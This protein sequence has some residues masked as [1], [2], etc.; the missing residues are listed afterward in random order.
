MNPW[1]ILG[2]GA[3]IGLVHAAYVFRAVRL[4]NGETGAG[5][6]PPP[7][8]YSI[9]TILLWTLLG[10]YVLAMWVIG[11]AGYLLFRRSR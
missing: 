3:A 6:R 1:Y 8:V 5:K 7:I 9:W 4:A 10:G 2:I 11:A